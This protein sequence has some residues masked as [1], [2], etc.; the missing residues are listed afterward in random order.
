MENSTR[1][2]IEMTVA[3]VILGTIGWF[4]VT[5]RMPAIAVVFWRCTFGAA[6]LLAICL[7]LGLFRVRMTLAQFGIAV[8][9][10]VAIVLNWVL[11]FGAFNHASISMATAVYNTQPFILVAF[12]SIFFAERLTVRKI[13]WLVLGF[14][15]ML[16]V[17]A[18]GPVVD[19]A[20]ASYLV[21]IL[22]AL[23]AALFW[24]IAALA[25]KKL[26]GI[27]PQL[28]ALIHVT[29]GALM[30]APFQGPSSIAASAQGW[31]LVL[32]VGIVH[33]GLMYILMYSA[34]QRLSTTKQAALSFIYPIVATLVDVVAFHQ[35]FTLAQV[36][37]AVAIL[38]AAAGMNLG[39]S[40]PGLARFNRTERAVG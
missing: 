24:A 10:G 5:S 12:G 4:V 31:G 28:V 26:T 1:G 14:A 13:A 21:G 3:M 30:L 35:R 16:L 32:I 15:G 34:I 7:G 36:G 40:I 11:L 22:M 6:V 38:I 37:G 20:G 27:P 8:L 39:W 19:P 33:T 17:I 29:V 23:G 25:A 2:S 18:A 9:G